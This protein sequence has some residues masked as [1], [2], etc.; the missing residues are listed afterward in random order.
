M[1]FISHK[2]KFLFVHIPRT[3]GTS[4]EETL[5]KYEIKDDTYLDYPGRKQTWHEKHSTI[6]LL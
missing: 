1:S 2:H 6:K 5:H 4:I 3:A